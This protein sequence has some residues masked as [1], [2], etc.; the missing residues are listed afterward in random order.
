MDITAVSTSNTSFYSKENTINILEK[1]K[2]QLQNQ[3]KQVNESNMDLKMKQDK[4]NVLHEKINEIEMQIKKNRINKV[5]SNYNK[6]KIENK[7][8][9]ENKNTQSAG[10]VVEINSAHMLSA[11]T[12]YSYLKTMD[13]VRTELKNELRAARSSGKSPEAIQGIEEKINNVESN[14]LKTS[15]KINDDLRKA[16][17]KV[18][19]VEKAEKEETK[20]TEI[21]KSNNGN[22]A[23]EIKAVQDSIENTNGQLT[24]PV[25]SN[26]TDAQEKNS[27]IQSMRKV[28]DI[29]I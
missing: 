15:D 6:S 13:K 14:M 18:E 20:N 4:L 10:T 29:R 12:G 7:S 23:K 28:I 2:M 11:V 22:K 21:N 5:K 24:I 19:K 26:K 9:N 27:E 8:N 16:S 1:Q 25:A 3:I 17:K